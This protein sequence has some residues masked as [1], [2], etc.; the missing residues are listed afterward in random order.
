MYHTD[1]FNPD[2]DLDG[3]NDYNDL[4]PLDYDMDGDGYI[5]GFELIDPEGAFYDARI[6]EC[7]ANDNFIKRYDNGDPIPEDDTANG[8][9]ND[10]DGDEREITLGYDDDW[11]ADGMSNNYECFHGIAYGGWQN[12]FLHNARYAVLIGGDIWAA[13]AGEGDVVAPF[14][15]NDIRDMYNALLSKGWIEEN[16]Y[17]WFYNG[18]NHECVNP[19][20]IIDGPV[21]KE[22]WL[23]TINSLKHLSTKND[24]FL[25]TINSHGSYYSAA[26]SNPSNLFGIYYV[27]DNST[28]SQHAFISDIPTNITYARSVIVIEACN[29]GG[30]IRN[31]WNDKSNT[32]LKA[33]NTMI[34]TACRI[35]RWA[36]A[37]TLDHKIFFSGFISK[38]SEADASIYDAYNMGVQATDASYL[39]DARNQD[40]QLEDNGDCLSEQNNDPNINTVYGGEYIPHTATDGTLS[41][42]TYI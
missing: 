2:T 18:F 12:E 19:S 36:N 17:L 34:V 38:L 11:D 29:A 10:M 24:F 13:K 16:I 41:S 21:T 27:T 22:N 42:Q 33:S 15:W 1:P 14:F 28:T 7:V 37:E 32:P 26:M 6:A 5:N 30:A 9:D 4:I 23:F 39:E 20:G 3:Q 25:L 8:G 35:D 40:P 31:Y